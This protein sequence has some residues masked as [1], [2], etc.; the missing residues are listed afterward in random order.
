[1]IGNDYGIRSTGSQP[2]QLSRNC[3]YDNRLGNYN[4][5]TQG[6]DDFSANPMLING[7]LGSYYLSQSTASQSNTSP[8]VNAAN[9][10]AQELGLNNQTTRTDGQGDQGMAD[11]GF[12]Y[13][14]PPGRIRFFPMVAHSH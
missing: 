3:F 14:R 10:S 7:P 5:I 2:D 9:Q 1:M 11:V 13:G 8:L 6:P 12:H 4:G